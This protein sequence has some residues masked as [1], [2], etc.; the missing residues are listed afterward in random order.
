M[1]KQTQRLL[2]ARIL[3]KISG[4]AEHRIFQKW[5][6]V[7]LLNI[8]VK[9]NV[10]LNL[11]NKYRNHNIV[12][13]CL[14]V[15]VQLDNVKNWEQ[16]SQFFEYEKQRVCLV[17]MKICSLIQSQIFNYFRAKPTLHKLH[18]I[19][20]HVPFMYFTKEPRKVEIINSITMMRSH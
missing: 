20:L 9:R 17:F 6:N 15:R 12:W 16:S 11:D 7:C 1:H 10:W 3:T 5:K 2:Q 14:H 8:S 19:W 18:G 4:H 13:Y